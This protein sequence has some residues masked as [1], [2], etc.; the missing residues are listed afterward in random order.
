MLIKPIKTKGIY[1]LLGDDPPLDAREIETPICPAC[2]G[3]GSKKALEIIRAPIRQT[4]TEEQSIDDARCWE[5]AGK[6]RIPTIKKRG[7]Q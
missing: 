1:P 2:K 5:C 3:T 6:G 7:E 4:D